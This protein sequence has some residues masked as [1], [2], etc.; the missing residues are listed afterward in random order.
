MR[1]DTVAIPR[2]LDNADTLE[3]ILCLATLIAVGEI[4]PDSKLSDSL[5]FFIEKTGSDC[6][7]CPFCEKCLAMIINQ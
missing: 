3:E 6:S 2:S 7:E 4:H 5:N 1:Q